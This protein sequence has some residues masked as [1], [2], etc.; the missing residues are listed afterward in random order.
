[1]EEN[2]VMQVTREERGTHLTTNGNPESWTDHHPILNFRKDGL[3]PREKNE[4]SV[5]IHELSLLNTSFLILAS[6][7]S[8]N[9][10]QEP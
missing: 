7:H 3:S 8:L 6:K 2:A 5:P 10:L 1:M 9:S 4:A